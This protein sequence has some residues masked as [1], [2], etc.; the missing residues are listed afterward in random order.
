MFQSGLLF[1]H[2]VFCLVRPVEIWHGKRVFRRNLTEL[3]NQLV[4][5]LHVLSLLSFCDGHV[6]GV[7]GKI[8]RTRADV[9]QPIK[10]S[11]AIVVGD[12]RFKVKFGDIWQ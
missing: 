6:I 5:E 8:R 3:L 1:L 4:I 12:V 2:C 10:A 9:V 7:D 11:V